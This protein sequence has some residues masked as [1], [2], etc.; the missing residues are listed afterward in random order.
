M[1]FLDQAKVFVRS[2]DGGAG[3]VS[4][5]REKYVEFGGP[6]GGDGGRGGDVIVECVGGLNTLID[7]R[8]RQHFKG[9]T[10]GH[11]M[12]RN[13]TGGKGADVILKVPVGTQILAEDNETLIADMTAEGQKFVLARGGN[14][15][16]G[17][18][19]FKSSTNQAPRRANPGLDGTEMW[20]W[21]RLKLIADAGLIGL[22]NA[23]KSTFLAAVSAAKPKIADYPFTTLHPN[24]GVAAVDGREFVL[25][26][27]PGL[28]EGAH[29]GVGIGDRFLGHV[30]RCR[31]L[32][33]L[34][35]GTGE[36]V[37]EAYRVVR[38]EIEAY[39]H[40][41][42]DK[43]EVVALSKIDALDEETRSERMTAL[44]KALGRPVLG[45]SSATGE[46]VEATLR[47]VFKVI[48]A[49]RAEEAEESVPAPAP[50]AGDWLKW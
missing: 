26:D 36:D 15:G 37:V 17:N 16:F 19:H 28:I 18:A 24:L 22:P 6:D 5:R 47:A 33:H 2:G 12:G 27:I 1:K 25:A 40:G 49:A 45:V 30:E 48:D 4:F 23:G 46:N 39:A 41:L 13:R 29:E 3:S 20:V 44:S 11:G 34:V 21:L 32:L 38:G 9:K 10:G 7:Y 14:G 50:D 31:V 35:D 42:A 43:P 8:F